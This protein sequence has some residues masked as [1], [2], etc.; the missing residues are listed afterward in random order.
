MKDI[1]QHPSWKRRCARRMAPLTYSIISTPSN[2]NKQT[3][4]KSV[5]KGEANVAESPN[6][7]GYQ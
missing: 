7:Y 4:A 5:K 6:G 1:K 2:K 3:T